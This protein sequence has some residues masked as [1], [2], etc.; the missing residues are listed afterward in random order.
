MKF[1]YY[2]NPIKLAFFANLYAI[3]GLLFMLWYVWLLGLLYISTVDGTTGGG[4][5]V[6]FVACLSIAPQTIVSAIC[7][8][9]FIV[10]ILFKHQMKNRFVKENKIYN[11]LFYI[12][13]VFN[14][15]VLF[16]AANFY[17]RV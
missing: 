17:F 13:F 10:E 8:L 3:I 4:G 6:V 9:L 1:N 11:L 2:K 7:F 15:L 16:L 5:G 12:G 14:T